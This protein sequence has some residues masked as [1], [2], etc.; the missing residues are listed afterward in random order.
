M[1]NV[2]LIKL[3]ALSLVMRLKELAS[4][5]LLN[6]NLLMYLDPTTEVKVPLRLP[7]LFP[8]PLLTLLS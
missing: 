7:E 2:H 1:D 5:L 3:L 4:S 8:D 6:A